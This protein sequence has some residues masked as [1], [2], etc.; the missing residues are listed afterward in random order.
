[1]AC[2]YTTPYP[3][4]HQPNIIGQFPFTGMI[5]VNQFKYCALDNLIALAV[6]DYDAPDFSTAFKIYPL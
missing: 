4:I 2:P 6:W 1:M 5:L 3:I